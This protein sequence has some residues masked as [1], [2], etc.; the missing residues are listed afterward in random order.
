MSILTTIRSH[1]LESLEDDTGGAKLT[2]LLGTHNIHVHATSPYC[3]TTSTGT[4][5]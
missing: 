5:Q 3:T 1:S 2:C 4:L